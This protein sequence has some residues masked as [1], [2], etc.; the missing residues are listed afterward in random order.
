MNEPKPTSL[1]LNMRLKP[2]EPP[3]HPR[4]ANY[5]NVGVAQGIASLE[6]WFLEP[7]RLTAIAQTAK[8]GQAAPKGVDGHLVTRVA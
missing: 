8:D 5:M 4:A 6:V 3:A 2:Y 1:P 7:A